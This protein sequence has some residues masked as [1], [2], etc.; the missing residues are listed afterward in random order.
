[1]VGS[2]SGITQQDVEP[3]PACY[4][5]AEHL[6]TPCFVCGVPLEH[7]DRTRESGDV[8]PYPLGIFNAL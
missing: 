1:M 8:H 2:G 4:Q 3:A 7:F 6:A 5:R